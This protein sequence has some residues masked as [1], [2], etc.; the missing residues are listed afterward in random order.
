MLPAVLLAALLLFG[1]QLGSIGLVDET[2]PLFAASARAMAESG[3]WLIPHVN[4]LARYDK[5]PLVYW[6]MAACYAL[7]AAPLWDPLGSWCAALPSA[8]AAAVLMLV[9]ACIVGRL[10]RLNHQP[11]SLLPLVAA[12]AF[13]LSPLVVLWSRIGVSDMLFTVLLAVAHL[14]SWQRYADGRWPWWP[15]WLALGLAVLTK[16]PAALVLWAGSW[17]MFA[18]MQADWQASLRALRP[19]LGLLVL[20]VVALPWYG[21][22]LLFE[23]EPFGR[24]FFGYHN[25]QRFTDV[26]NGHSAPWWF[27]GAMLLIGNAPFT[28][29]L[30]FGLLRALR[31]RVR[32]APQSL[33]RFA[34]CWLLM[35]LLLFS[36]AATKLPSYWLPATPAAALLIALPLLK[37]SSSLRRCLQAT[38]LLT[39]LC[40]AL[41]LASPWWL[42]WVRDPEL[43]ALATTL[44]A[45]FLWPRAALLLSCAA[46]VSWV[47]LRR[48]LQQMLALQLGW[49]AI[50]PSLVVPLAAHA[51]RWRSAPVRVMA[52]EVQRQRRPR[53]PLA[54]VGVIKPSLHFY[55][56]QIVAYEGR[57]RTALVNLHDRLAHEPR[58][59]H[60]SA[61]S[62]ALL[63][64]GRQDLGEL[65]Y[66]AP[67][68]PQPL[69][70]AGP[71]R[72]WRVSRQALKDQARQLIDQRRVRP[73]WRVPRPERF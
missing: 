20:A 42:A 32:G 3:E 40:G 61:E 47:L 34:A 29:L 9:L 54:M 60:G 72:L 15:A 28:P 57:S 1:W 19:R 50:V 55:S 46:A 66:W 64:V 4:G 51:D 23:G 69:A 2:P 44:G 26:V 24:S 33:E 25:L 16:G 36:V 73:N 58:L 52:A 49:L 39:L 12:L 18:A 27:F 8:I 70:K 53:E 14:S 62:A 67:L 63:V 31:G 45:S 48:P 5:P 35:V 22:A 6:L 30:L 68:L 65:P 11:A 10:Q 13:G 7:P 71:Y 56:R 43:P 37:P 17:L 41:L 21:L 38:A 59:Q